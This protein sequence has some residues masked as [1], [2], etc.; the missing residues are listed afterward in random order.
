VKGKSR[1]LAYI[2]RHYPEKF[3][4][5][6]KQG[7]WA[8][9]SKILK[10]LN[11]HMD[12]LEYIVENDSKG[13]YSFTNDKKYIRANQGHSIQVDLGLQPTQPPNILYHGTVKDFLDKILESGLKKMKRHA[14]H[15]SAEKDT[16]KEVANRR[17][18]ESIILKINSKQMFE[19]GY[20]FYVSENEVWLTDNVPSKY[21]TRLN[22]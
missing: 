12:K 5:T 7:G 3:D 18:S 9:T 14:V 10:A 11:I 17:K 1:K 20:V 13:R 2:L 21:I 19:D 22:K 8:D 4:I 16:A 15:L 6:L